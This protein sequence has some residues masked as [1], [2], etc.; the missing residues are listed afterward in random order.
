MF[1]FFYGSPIA[2]VL[3]LQK[4][5]CLFFQISVTQYWESFRGGIS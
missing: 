1:F 3:D 4:I 5:A 2:L